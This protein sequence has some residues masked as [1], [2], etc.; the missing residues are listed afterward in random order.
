MPDTHISEWARANHV[1]MDRLYA[2]EER[3]GGARA[4]GVGVPALSREALS[5]FAPQEWER[6]KNR[7]I[8]ETWLREAKGRVNK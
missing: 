6:L 7:M 8:Y 4:L 3:E 5:V 1:E 2:T